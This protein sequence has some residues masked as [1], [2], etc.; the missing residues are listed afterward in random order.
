MTPTAFGPDWWIPPRKGGGLRLGLGLLA[1][2]LLLAALGGVLGFLVGGSTQTEADQV[3]AVATTL[4][5]LGGGGGGFCLP[6]PSLPPP[7]SAPPRP[8]P[9]P[10]PWAWWR[11]RRSRRSASPPALRPRC[12][13]GRRDDA[14]S[15]PSPRRGRRRAPCSARSPRF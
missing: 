11:S 4:R 6:P 8:P 2:T 7:P 12:C 13:C 9:P 5:A 1:A 14:P 3:P 10:R 15:W